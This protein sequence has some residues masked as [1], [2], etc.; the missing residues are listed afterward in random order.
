MPDKRAGKRGRKSDP[1]FFEPKKL[2]TIAN[3]LYFWSLILMVCGYGWQGIPN[4]LLKSNNHT[5]K[6]MTITGAR[7]VLR[8]DSTRGRSDEVDTRRIPQAD[9][10][11]WPT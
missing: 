4:A 2:P 6:A 10:A 5:L 9:A 11:K 3:S 7:G 8:A 1:V